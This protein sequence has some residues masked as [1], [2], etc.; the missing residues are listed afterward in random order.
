LLRFSFATFLAVGFL[1]H[2]P[3]TRDLI[4]RFGHV[5]LTRDLILRFLPEG[6]CTCAALQPVKLPVR[7]CAA[8]FDFVF[9]AISCM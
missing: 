2:V 5:P 6:F 4:L 8:M 3:L 1:G 9:K 7:V